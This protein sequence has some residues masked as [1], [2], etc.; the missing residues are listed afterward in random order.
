MLTWLYTA[1]LMLVVFISTYP[2]AFVLPLFVEERNGKLDNNTTVGLGYY[3]P[4]WLS[5]FQTPDNSID[6]DQGW[7]E[8]HMQWRFK[9]PTKIATYLGRVGWLW[10]NAAYGV[11]LAPMIPYER[12]VLVK[13]DSDVGDNPFKEGSFLVET[14]DG[15]LFHYRLVKKIPFTNR[16][17]YFNFGWNIHGLLNHPEP[18][19][20]ATYALSIRVKSL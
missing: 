19:Y 18:E 16:F 20:M 2:L 10:R 17:M 3:L 5:W 13:G 12:V 15:R 4:D 14:Q 11:G 8:E 6:G 9:F 1:P 7:R